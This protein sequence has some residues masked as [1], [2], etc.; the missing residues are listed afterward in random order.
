MIPIHI[1]CYMPSLKKISVRG[2][3]R[4]MM[5]LTYN[6][7]VVAIMAVL[8]YEMDKWWLVLFAI[9]LMVRKIEVEDD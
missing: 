4:M 8:A 2:A 9:L 5:V 7:F 3:S 6:A 1:L